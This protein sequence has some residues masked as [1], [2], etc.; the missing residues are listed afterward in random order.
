MS[1]AQ[2]LALLAAIAWTKGN[3]NSDA[4]SAM[5]MEFVL[6][7]RKKAKLMAATDKLLGREGMPNVDLEAHERD[8]ERRAGCGVE[9][10]R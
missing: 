8:L 10:E 9:H 2:I 1:D 3:V 4:A 5:A 6:Q 7:G